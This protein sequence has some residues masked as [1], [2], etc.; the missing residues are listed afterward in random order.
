MPDVYL[1]TFEFD[2]GYNEFN[3]VTLTNQSS[4]NGIVTTDAVRFGG[5]M[6]NIERFGQTSG[7]PRAIE[8]ARY[9]AQWAGMPYSVYSGR[10]GTDDYADD[11]NVR[12]FMTNYLG[13]GSCYMPNLEGQKIPIELSLA[14]HSDAGYF[15]N[16]KDI[17]GALAICTTNHNEGKLNAGISRMASRDLADALLSN[18]VLDLKYKYSTWN[19]RELYDRNYSESRVPEVPSAILETMS[20]QSFPDMRYGQDPNFRF[21][22]ARSIY[23]TLL[24]YINDQYGTSFVVAPLAPDNFPCSIPLWAM[25]ISITGRMLRRLRTRLSSNLVRPIISVFQLSIVAVKV[26]VQR[27]SLPTT[28]LRPPRR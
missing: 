22:L 3:R 11:I 26:S 10:Q 15:K 20:H 9:Y 8:G 13:G 1:G 23:K 4:H 28:N 2:A 17:W 6:G 5:G 25:P 7:M 21:T 18:E 16:G 19:R 27:C 14:I 12:S 24:R